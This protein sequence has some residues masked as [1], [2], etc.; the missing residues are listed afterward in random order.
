[1][2]ALQLPANEL[3][4]CCVTLGNSQKQRNIQMTRDQIEL[5]PRLQPVQT[6]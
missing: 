1:M 4:V 5:P 3:F 2:A 6:H